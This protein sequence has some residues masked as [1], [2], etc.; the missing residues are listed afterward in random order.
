MFTF[1][2]LMIIAIIVLAAGWII[3]GVWMHKV[4]QEEKKKP[5]IASERLQQTRSEITD[6]A[7]KMAEFQSP[8]KKET[9][10]K[11]KSS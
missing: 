6:W 4:R 7:K 11:N 1:K 9:P 5:K 10:E 2:V 3:Y 8:I